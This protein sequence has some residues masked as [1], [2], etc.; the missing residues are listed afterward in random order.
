[1][2]NTPVEKHSPGFK[3]E[4]LSQND[5]GN[6]YKYKIGKGIASGLSGFIFG[7]LAGA[8]AIAL[9]WWAYNASRIRT[10]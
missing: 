7:F 5:T 4:F 3:Q 2:E 9:I 10:P 8:I 1:M 6:A